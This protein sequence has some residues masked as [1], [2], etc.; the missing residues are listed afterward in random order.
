MWSLLRLFRYSKFLPFWRPEDVLRSKKQNFCLKVRPG[1][2]RDRRESIQHKLVRE[3]T[4]LI[5]QFTSKIGNY[6]FQQI[7]KNLC[8]LLLFSLNLH[9]TLQ[10]REKEPLQAS[11]HVQNFYQSPPAAEQEKPGNRRYWHYSSV[12]EVI[13][14]NNY[15]NPMKSNTFLLKAALARRK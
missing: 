8:V 11:L 6:K 14:R 9:W 4:I 1:A 5:L 10:T 7:L 13:A 12:L 15:F 2:A 3:K